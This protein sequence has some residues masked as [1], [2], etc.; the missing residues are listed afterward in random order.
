[1]AKATLNKKFKTYTGKLPPNGHRFY[2]TNRF[3][4]EIIS[5]MPEHRDPD[6][7]TEAQ[8][9]AFQLIK[10]ASALADADLRDP[11]K[12][13]EWLKKWHDSFSNRRAKHYKTL[14]GFVIAAIRSRL[15]V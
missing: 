4:Q 2:L 11:V 3:G 9:Q 12:H 1:M 10:Q 14:R 7:V 5:H 8:R 15:A 6:S 13:D